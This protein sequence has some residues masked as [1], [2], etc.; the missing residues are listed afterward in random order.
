MRTVEESTDVAYVTWQEQT[1]K[2]IRRTAGWLEELE[3]I[4]AKLVEVHKDL[5]IVF[6]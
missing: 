4:E 6:D 5:G 3:A 2:L 1:G